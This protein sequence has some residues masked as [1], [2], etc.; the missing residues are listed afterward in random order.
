MIDQQHV[1]DEYKS[2]I[3]S[4]MNHQSISK[5]AKNKATK[6]YASMEKIFESEETSTF[7]ERM[8]AKVC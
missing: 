8:A 7:F 1:Q 4:M 3:H 6:L 2:H 5:H